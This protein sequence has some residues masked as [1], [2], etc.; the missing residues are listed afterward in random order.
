MGECGPNL[1]SLG[2]VQKKSAVRTAEANSPHRC[3]QNQFSDL[4]KIV[5]ATKKQ[6]HYRTE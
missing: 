6:Q 5:L 1:V 2:K 3:Y 4:G